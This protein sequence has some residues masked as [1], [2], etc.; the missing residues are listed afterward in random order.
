MDMIITEGVLLLYIYL[1]IFDALF[2]SR[3]FP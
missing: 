3:E 2:L 1:H